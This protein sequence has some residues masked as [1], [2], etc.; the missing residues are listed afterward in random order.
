MENTAMQDLIEQIEKKIS[1]IKGDKR[2]SRIV[3]GRYVDCLVMAKSLLP[4]EKQ[5]LIDFH[6]GTM[7]QGLI[8]EGE[9]KWQDGYSPKIT[10]VAEQYY[11]STF[12][13]D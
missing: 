6:I 11:N 10:Q 12:K 4:K 1:L 9:K 2:E 3:R 7:K 5:Q 8:H 13:Q